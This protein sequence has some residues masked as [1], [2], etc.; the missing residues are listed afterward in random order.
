MEKLYDGVT[1][2]PL[3]PFDDLMPCISSTSPLL[4]SYHEYSD[5]EHKTLT[6]SQVEKI[7]LKNS[8]GN[9]SGELRWTEAYTRLYPAI[10]MFNHSKHPNCTFLGTGK[11]NV[12]ILV[13]KK[14]VKKG[15]ELTVS[16]TLDE[17]KA[18]SHWGVE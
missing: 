7:V 14:H 3:V 15:E 9:S 18:K 17:A 16:Y 8:H 11:K 2:K 13:T 4:P 1:M 10:S 6:N 5:E 12:L